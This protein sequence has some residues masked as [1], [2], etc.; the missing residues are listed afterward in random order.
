M[1]L[2]EE[3][4]L[5]RE[6]VESFAIGKDYQFSI[7]GAKKRSIAFLVILTFCLYLE[8]G[9]HIASMGYP[10]FGGNVMLINFIGVINLIIYW[11]LMI[12]LFIGSFFK[13]HIY[14]Q[15][16]YFLCST[17]LKYFMLW[18]CIYV[19]LVLSVGVIASTT[20]VLVENFLFI[21]VALELP[22][23]ISFCISLHKKISKIKKG[24]YRLGTANYREQEEKI[25]KITGKFGKKKF[26]VSQ[27]IVA[28][29][30]ICIFSID[31]DKYM[32]SDRVFL[33]VMIFMLLFLSVRLAIVSYNW[34][35]Y[36]LVAYF[37]YKFEDFN[38]PKEVLMDKWIK[39]IQFNKGKVILK[40]ILGIISSIYGITSVLY[41]YVLWSDLT[42][43]STMTLEEFDTYASSFMGSFLLNVICITV[44]LWCF[45]SVK[46]AIKYRKSP[47]FKHDSTF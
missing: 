1:S 20:D 6:N 22:L 41:R 21:L 24:E 28:I 13:F 2:M 18:Q 23:I 9:F 44:T 3:I 17:L 30:L 27:L 26:S 43:I 38:E 7:D 31:V 29:G 11:F 47:K 45:T 12:V 8:V 36:A 14:F 15:K 40:I 39:G 10:A 34:T 32:L 35:D 42:N 4:K 37:K 46:D 5:I 19:M 16:G 25:N 33:I